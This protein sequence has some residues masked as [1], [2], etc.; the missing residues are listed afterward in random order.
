MLAQ[1]DTA[2]RHNME[3]TK[4][5]PGAVDKSL[6]AVLPRIVA[7]RRHRGEGHHCIER[8]FLARLHGEG[9]QLENLRARPAL[10]LHEMH[11]IVN[12]QALRAVRRAFDFKG[13]AHGSA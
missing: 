12:E 1:P 9:A 11:G 3:L 8:Y 6:D 7:A 5:V 2:L 4:V 13:Q 10:G